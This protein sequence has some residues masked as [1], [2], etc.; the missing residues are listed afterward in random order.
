VHR[1][2]GRFGEARA[3]DALLASLGLRTAACAVGIAFGA[4]A[5]AGVALVVREGP[6]PGKLLVGFMQPLV[7]CGVMAAAVLLVHRG[8]AGTHPA[9]QLV[10]EIAVG[11]I[12]YV[13]AALVI[14]RDSSRD[15]L[16]LLK[17]ALS[18][19]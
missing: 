5:I 3:G 10:I 1:G 19:G 6:S 11:G 13:L 8:L 2:V 15:L 4:T 14:A 18:R 17:K 12:A 16:G 9:I 7:A